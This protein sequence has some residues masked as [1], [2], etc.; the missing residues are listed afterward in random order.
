MRKVDFRLPRKGNSNSHGARPVHLIITMETWIR[1]GS[2][3]RKNSLYKE[4]IKRVE[5][6]LRDLPST[7]YVSRLEDPCMRRML[8]YLVTYASG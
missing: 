5:Y 3:S 7:P 1:T 4:G 6:L 8:V 2:L